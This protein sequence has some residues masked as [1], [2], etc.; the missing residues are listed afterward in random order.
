MP[1]QKFSNGSRIK[2]SEDCFWANG[3]SGTITVPPA[4]V[5]QIAGNWNGVSRVVDTPK[6]AKTF[7]W[8]QFAERQFD[9]DGD[10]PFFGA[11]FEP[12][13]LIPDSA[14]SKLEEIPTEDIEAVWYENKTIDLI[15]EF[16]AFLKHEVQKDSASYG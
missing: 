8:V 14:T 10:G 12:R 5:Q 6:G 13:Y 16:K 4:K 1:S 11:E 7:Y 3:A 9:P 2:I 15:I